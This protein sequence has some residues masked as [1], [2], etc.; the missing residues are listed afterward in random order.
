[1]CQT[2]AQHASQHEADKHGEVHLVTGRLALFTGRYAFGIPGLDEAES[3]RLLSNLI[4]FACRPPRAYA[5]RWHPGDVVI[6]DNRWCRTE[7]PYDYRA[8]RAFV[9]VLGTLSGSVGWRCC[10][11]PTR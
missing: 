9:T 7:R 8:V 2:C 1:M 11:G 5:H 3:E 6:R 10:R 4:D